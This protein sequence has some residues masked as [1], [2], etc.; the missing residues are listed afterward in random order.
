LGK[1]ATLLTA[2]LLLLH[3]LATVNY[4]DFASASVEYLKILQV[5][6]QKQYDLDWYENWFY[7]QATGLLTF[8]TGEEQLNF[9]Y[10]QVGSFS[11]KSTTWKWAWD[12]DHTLDSVKQT[13]Q[14]IKEFGQQSNF[15]KLV[16]G[17]FV[18]NEIEAWEFTA[19]AAK[20][21]NGIGAYRPVGDDQL[22]VYLVIAAFVDNETAKSIKD[23]YVEC[24]KHEYRRA[25][26]V[27]RHLNHSTKVG[28][29]EAFETF[30]DMD[31]LEEDD[32]QAWC[33]ECELIRQ[34]EDGWNDESMAFAAIKMVCEKCYFEMKEVNL[35]YR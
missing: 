1:H 29:E 28:F 8:S 5:N 27:C 25:A 4:D 33:D 26:F 14:L 10:F 34:K 20:I 31:L 6:F 22:Q 18:S 21:G 19:I 30:E 32:L 24:G 3:K 16:E 2:E 17:C 15:P 11:N 23:R 9:S 13:T 7:N 12:N 35:G